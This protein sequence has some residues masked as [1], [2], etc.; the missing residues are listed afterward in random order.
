MTEQRVPIEII[1]TE[2][3]AVR[4]RG[5]ARMRGVTVD[6]YRNEAG[7]P[8]RCGAGEAVVVV[9]KMMVEEDDAG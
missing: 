1:N 9:T 7:H 6:Q 4:A 3:Q 5:T 8:L 2:T